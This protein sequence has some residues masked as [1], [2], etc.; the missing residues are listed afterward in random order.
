MARSGPDQVAWSRR[1]ILSGPG[2]ALYFNTGL[3]HGMTISTRTGSSP[4]KIPCE[5]ILMIDSSL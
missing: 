2:P 5:P 3:G 1:L 4:K